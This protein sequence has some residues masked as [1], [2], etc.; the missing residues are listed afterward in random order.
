[1]KKREETI[2]F[3]VLWYYRIIF[4]TLQNCNIFKVFWI[5]AIF[6][7]ILI[8]KEILKKD[9]KLDK[10]KKNVCTKLF[11]FKIQ[12]KNKSF[13]VFFQS[14]K[15]SISSWQWPR[16]SFWAAFSAVYWGWMWLPGETKTTVSTWFLCCLVKHFAAWKSHALPRKFYMYK[17]KYI[18]NIYKKPSTFY[19]T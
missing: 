14:K 2:R 3:M 10:N 6:K 17:R 8:N 12:I 1:M 13:Q 7:W 18:L 9:Y 16:S 19:S 5:F 15:N 4:K 11:V